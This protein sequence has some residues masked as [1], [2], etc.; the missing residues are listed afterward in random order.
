M[1]SLFA[2]WLAPQIEQVLD[3][4]RRALALGGTMAAD[5]LEL[6]RLEWQDEKDRLA[7]LALLSLVA[8]VLAAL[9]L[10]FVGVLVIAAAWDTPWRLWAV[11]AVALATGLGCTAA[12]MAAL[13]QWRRGDEA[14]AMLR[15]ELEADLQALRGER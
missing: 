8:V 6:A 14:F 11:A 13:R 9:T 2:R 12:C 10:V 1:A 7:R 5:R 4:A 3:L 15:A